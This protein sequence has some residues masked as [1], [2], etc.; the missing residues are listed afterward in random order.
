MKKSVLKLFSPIIYSLCLTLAL[1]EVKNPELNVQSPIDPKKINFQPL[2]HQKILNAGQRPCFSIFLHCRYPALAN[3]P[4][5]P[6]SAY[7]VRRVAPMAQESVLQKFVF[8]LPFP[9]L[10]AIPPELC[11][12]PCRVID[13][14]GACQGT[15]IAGRLLTPGSGRAFFYEFPRSLPGQAIPRG[16][17]YYPAATPTA[18]NVSRREEK[19][20]GDKK[21]AGQTP[22]TAITAMGATRQYAMYWMS[23]R[24]TTTSDFPFSDQGR[25]QMG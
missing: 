20:K 14:T 8:S 17:F 12:K 22:P 2:I 21:G 7:S 10:I 24:P 18:H 5:Y 6:A 19:E 23:A 16:H 25:S 1:K 15:S 9:K 4:T 11:I 13:P 3:H